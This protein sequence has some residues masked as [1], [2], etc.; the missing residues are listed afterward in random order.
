MLGAA[1]RLNLVGAGRLGCTRAH[2]A[3]VVE[4]GCAHDLDPNVGHAHAPRSAFALQLTPADHLSR[5]ATRVLT[6]EHPARGL[7]QTS[8]RVWN[9][10]ASG[11]PYAPQTYPLGLSSPAPNNYSKGIIMINPPKEMQETHF[12]GGIDMLLA[13]L[14]DSIDPP[15]PSEVPLPPGATKLSDRYARGRV[16]G[17][18]ISTPER[19][20]TVT[21]ANGLIGA[22]LRSHRG[23]TT[24]IIAYDPLSKRIETASGS[25]Y[26]LGMPDTAFAARGRHVLRKLGF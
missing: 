20:A 26:E 15:S 13:E 17:W 5:A 4:V 9:I 16:S 14:G 12:M 1:P 21:D 10:M 18:W 11:F 19:D 3:G 7:A 23:S 2:A 24:A 8:S 22:I 25:I 6:D